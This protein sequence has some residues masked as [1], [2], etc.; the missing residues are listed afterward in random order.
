MSSAQRTDMQDRAGDRLEDRTHPFDQLCVSAQ[1]INRLAM[2]GGDLASGK[3]RLQKRGPSLVEHG[4]E[5]NVQRAE[6]VLDWTTIWSGPSA[7][8]I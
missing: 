1:I 7:G 5:F 8:A 2:L 3:G 6:I 4:R